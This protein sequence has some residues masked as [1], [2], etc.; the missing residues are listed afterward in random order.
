MV[1]DEQRK[2]GVHCAAAYDMYGTEHNST[3]NRATTVSINQD[4]IF[5]WLQT[6]VNLGQNL[7]PLD[8][9]RGAGLYEFLLLETP[10]ETIP[11]KVKR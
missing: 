5:E 1:D 2:P 11:G 9:S 10:R 8:A 6:T 4:W 7:D 3:F